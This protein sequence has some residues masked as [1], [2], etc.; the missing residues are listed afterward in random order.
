MKFEKQDFC[1]VVCFTT[2]ELKENDFF[3][4]RVTLTLILIKVES[5]VLIKSDTK[6]NQEI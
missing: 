4:Q 2:F 3:S 1:H 5:H 6:H